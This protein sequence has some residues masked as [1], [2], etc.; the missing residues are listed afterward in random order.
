MTSP[1]LSSLIDDDG[2]VPLPTGPTT[3]IQNQV[4]MAE[5]VRLVDDEMLVSLLFTNHLLDGSDNCEGFVEEEQEVDFSERNVYVSHPIFPDDR[6]SF[7]E[8]DRKDTCLGKLQWMDCKKL[9]TDNQWEMIAQD[10]VISQRFRYRFL[11]RNREQTNQKKKEDDYLSVG[12]GVKPVRKEFEA[13]ITSC[14]GESGPFFQLV[15]LI[16][17]RFLEWSDTSIVSKYYKSYEF[18]W[19]RKRLDIDPKK[20]SQPSLIL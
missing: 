14:T 4:V 5:K 6:L 19:S 9:I 7:K 10:C 3:E 15:P 11:Y 1:V 12:I 8:L 13:R 18:K 17:N 2:T 20:M 16:G